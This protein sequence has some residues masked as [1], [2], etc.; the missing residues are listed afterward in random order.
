MG[1]DF[2]DD[3]KKIVELVIKL[4]EEAT[5]QC[6]L[7]RHKLDGKA[8]AKGDQWFDLYEY[9]EQKMRNKFMTL[10]GQRVAALDKGD[11]TALAKVLKDFNDELALKKKRT[12]DL[13]PLWLDDQRKRLE[14]AVG[15]K[16]EESSAHM[17]KHFGDEF[18][19]MAQMA[20]IMALKKGMDPYKAKKGLKKPM[21][22]GEVAA[23]YGYS[24]QDFT[25]INGLLRDPKDPPVDPA[26]FKPYSDA[27]RKGLAKLPVYKKGPVVRCDRSAEHFI[28]EV[29]KDGTRTEH[30]F[31]SAGPKKVPGFGEVVSI[32][33]KIV[34]GRE[35]T[36]FS[37]HETE[38]EILFPPEA[39]FRFVSFTDGKNSAITNHKD[40]EGK[41]D[42]TLKVGEF[43][44]EQVR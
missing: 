23:I 6:N 34:T 5:A 22:M 9:F 42:G 4:A 27:C 38:G 20:E 36:Q 31:V 19:E 16:G 17:S 21:E 41:V 24:T 12:D 30:A 7:I 18:L 10:N 25:K 35:I 11:E 39:V 28:Q 8:P 26:V 37:L 40:L 32:I 43:V 29:I 15:K 2:R 33:T 44:F 1:V 3:K 14:K 13:K